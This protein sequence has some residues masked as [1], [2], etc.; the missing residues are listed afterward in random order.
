M[1]GRIVEVHDHAWE[2]VTVNHPELTDDLDDVLRTMTAAEAIEPD[3]RPGRQRYYR[4]RQGSRWLRVVTVFAGEFD[5]FVTAFEQSNPPSG[6][7][8]P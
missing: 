4:Q 6:A 1:D 5:R 8:L 2:H 3:P 7:S